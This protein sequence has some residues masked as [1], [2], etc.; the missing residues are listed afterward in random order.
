MNDTYI[1]TAYDADC[2]YHS[3]FSPIFCFLLGKLKI[4]SHDACNIPP[5]TLKGAWEPLITT[6]ELE[7]G[8][9]ILDQRDQ[10]RGRKCHHNLVFCVSRSKINFLCRSI[11]GQI[12]QE[13]Q[14]IQVDPELIPKI[15]AV[16]THDIAEKMGH[17][18]PDERQVLE[19][20]LKVSVPYYESGCCIENY[21]TRFSVVTKKSSHTIGI[22]DTL[23]V[24]AG[25]FR[26]SAREWERFCL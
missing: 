15:R 5:K 13:L 23:C 20:A 2:V 11:D 24:L 21:R 1:V 4:S 22:T 17:L 19:N 9:V 16:Y 26:Y 25:Y 14:K 8:M 6:E 3:N 18:R 7:R 10:K 12:P